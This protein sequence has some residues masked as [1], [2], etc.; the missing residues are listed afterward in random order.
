[1]TQIKLNTVTNCP[2][3]RWL[4]GSLVDWLTGCM[5]SWLADNMWVETQKSVNHDVFPAIIFIWHPRSNTFTDLGFK[6][7]ATGNVS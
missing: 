7:R 4:A 6:H 5:T 1:M 3:D 2:I